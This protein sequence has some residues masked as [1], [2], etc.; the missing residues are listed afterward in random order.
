MAPDHPRHRHDNGLILSEPPGSPRSLMRMIGLLEALAGRPQGMSLVD[1]SQSLDSPKSSL[2]TLLRPLTAS[3]HLLHASARY[4]LGPAAFR[5][6]GT[7]LASQRMP[8]QLRAALEWLARESGETAILTAIDR[9]AG[10]V[11]YVEVI[12]SEQPVRY[13]VP[14]GSTRPLYS[15]AA[16]RMLLACQDKAWCEAYLKRTPLRAIT[17]RS[18]TSVVALRKILAETRRQGFSVTIGETILGAA[19]CAAPV[20]GMDG[21]VNAALL[22]GAP[23]I[24]FERSLKRITALVTEAAARA[25][26]GVP[27]A[28]ATAANPSENPAPASRGK[29]P[30]PRA[31]RAR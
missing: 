30:S 7:M 17:P 28:V 6:A 29:P 18:T 22:I 20:V 21:Q 1:L 24:R 4:R 16:G 3:G 5:L 8:E 26:A 12:P 13:V 23:A 14:S 9:D 25:S 2:L 11:T 15:S 19:G 27:R 10:L 31:P